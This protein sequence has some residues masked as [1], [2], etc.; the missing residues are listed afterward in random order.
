MSPYQKIDLQLQDAVADIKTGVLQLPE[1]QR[2]FRWK[3]SEQTSLLAS[4]QRNYPVG[5]ILLLEIF[6]LP[7]GHF[8]VFL[9]LPWVGLDTWCWMDNR[10]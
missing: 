10:D 8:P 1:F 2:K 4:I 9:P 3:Q 5:S 6:R 7:Y